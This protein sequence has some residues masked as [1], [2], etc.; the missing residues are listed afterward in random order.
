MKKRKKTLGAWGSQGPE[1][2][3]GGKSIRMLARHLRA[4]R[5]AEAQGKR[6]LFSA[7]VLSAPLVAFCKP[8]LRSLLLPAH[9]HCRVLPR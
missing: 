1:T 6:Q 2:V 7:N 8:T 4:L 5:T 9:G 3:M